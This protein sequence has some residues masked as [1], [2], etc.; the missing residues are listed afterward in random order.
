MDDVYFIFNGINSLN[1]GVEISAFPPITKPER[2]VQTLDIPGRSG[3]LHIDDGTYSS[4]T[5]EIECIVDP[6]SK[7]KQKIDKIL[8]W[9]DGKGDLIISTEPDKVYTAYVIQSIPLTNVIGVFPQFL[10]T[11]EV[12]PLKK[13]VNFRNEIVKIT[14]KTMINNVGTVDSTPTITIYGSGN[15]ILKINDEEFSI[16]N[17]DQYITINSELLE[18]YKD[19]INQNN[20]YN[21]FDFPKFKIGENT[22]GFKGNVQKIV[23][24]PNWRWL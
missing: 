24:V 4:Y 15:V 13:S 6:F 5:L 23:I 16:R 14:K 21:N 17:V 8:N 10:V 19:D 3:T 12:Q 2:K 18:V 9:L 7:N 1:M 20:K 22:I 11:F